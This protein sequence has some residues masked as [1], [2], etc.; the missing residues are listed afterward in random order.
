MGFLTLS[1]RVCLA[2]GIVAALASCAKKSEKASLEMNFDW[3][4][5]RSKD[6]AYRGKVSSLSAPPLA[7]LNM[8]VVNAT[9]APKPFSWDRHN[10]PDPDTAVA[11]TSIELDGVKQGKG[12]IVQVVALFESSAGM[13]F[14]Y[15]SK[16]IDIGSASPPAV[17]ITITN[18]VTGAITEGDFV[19]QFVPATGAPPTGRVSYMFNPPDGGPQV[20]VHQTEMFRGW[21]RLTALS[22]KLLTFSSSNPVITSLLSDATILNDSMF[23]NGYAAQAVRV[24][25][26]AHSADESHDNSFDMSDRG[27]SVLNIGFFGPGATS[28]PRKVCYSGVIA[29]IPNLFMDS[30]HTGGQEIQWYGKNVPPGAPA[31]YAFVE[32]VSATPFKGGLTTAENGSCAV[33]SVGVNDEFVH[34]IKFDPLAMVHSDSVVPFRGPFIPVSFSNG[35]AQYVTLTANGPNY[36]I[37]WKVLPGMTNTDFGGAVVFHRQVLGDSSDDNELRKNDGFACEEMAAGKF[38]P[39]FASV[40]VNPLDQLLTINTPDVSKLQAIVCVKDDTG[41]FYNGAVMAYQSG[42]GYQSYDLKM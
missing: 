5:I 10:Q 15:G 20:L 36:D 14:Y 4:Q 18:L 2:V 32:G 23:N 1:K 3:H 40:S 30:T 16:T 26:P 35:Y 29:P 38:S 41:R 39:A 12:I 27:E 34:Y 24:R 42:G 28:L 7:T 25:V 6:L 22:T 31:K 13:E 9:G 19:G 8:V 21:I 11:P 37:A 17:D 33:P